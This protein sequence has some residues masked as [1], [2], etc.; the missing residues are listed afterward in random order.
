[1]DTQINGSSLSSM[2]SIHVTPESTWDGLAA[3]LRSGR[4][5]PRQ[6]VLLVLPPKP[7]PILVRP[8]DFRAFKRLKRELDINM[9]FVIPGQGNARLRAWARQAG[10]PAYSTQEELGQALDR[11]LLR[12]PALHRTGGLVARSHVAGSPGVDQPGALSSLDSSTRGD[13]VLQT[14]EPVPEHTQR[15]VIHDYVEG[16]CLEDYLMH[17]ASPME[18]IAVLAIGAQLLETLKNLAGQ[19]LPV[20]HGDIRPAN[21]VINARDNRVHLIG[22]PGLPAEDESTEGTQERR[23]GSPGYASPEQVQG[24]ADGRSD[25]YSL[26]ATMHRLLTNCDPA[27]YPPHNYPPVTLYNPRIS[28]ETERLLARAL[29]FDPTL[30]YQSAAE[31]KR[32]VEALLAA[33]RSVPQ[34]LLQSVALETQPSNGKHPPLGQAASPQRRWMGAPGPPFR[35]KRLGIAGAALLLLLVAVV[36]TASPLIFAPSP[37]GQPARAA[38]GLGIGV[39]RAPDGE[40]IGLSDGNFAFDTGADRSDRALKIQASARFRAGDIGSAET[41]WSSAV[42]QDTSDAE[43]LIYLEDQRVKDSG[44]PYITLVVGTMNSGTYVGLG[45]DDLQGA[46]IAQHEYNA[47]LKLPGKEQ[48]RLLI[49]STGNERDYAVPVAQQIVRAAQSDPTIVGV[50]GWPYSSRTENVVAILANARIPILSQMASSV[51]LTGIS[52]YFFRIVPPDSVQAALGA[53]YV[54]QVI[55]ARAAALFLDPSEAYSKSIGDSFKAKFTADGNTIVATEDY[56]IGKPETIPARL[57]DALSHNPDV[58]YFAGMAADA[59]TLLVNLPVSGPFA[60]LQIMGGDGL[61]EVH[62]YS[63]AA[64]PNF[65]RLRFT[66]FAYPDEW[67]GQ[68]LGR[69]APAFFRDYAS[70]FDPQ[71]QHTSAPYGYDRANGDAMLSYDA[72][73]VLLEAS[74]VALQTTPGEMLP[75]DLDR[76]LT[77]IQGPKA[78]QGVTGQIAFGPN[79]DPINKAVVVL[80][81]SP[82]RFIEM[83]GVQGTFLKS[84]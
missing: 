68:G 45:R 11:G 51:A 56:T 76:A 60:H 28:P 53:R 25:L 63:Q 55:H 26:A 38:P 18:E 48:V 10:F 43:A 19:S 82:E 61:Y 57:Q 30:R 41:L 49:A 14:A 67:E 1:M 5:M 50:M 71:R 69:Q 42:G 8:D 58:I 44:Y 21:I 66:A 40:Y 6:P 36:L 27:T 72:V 73:V 23:T 35:G 9:F 54:E 3:E 29:T 65:N 13:G 15:F 52:P 39:S 79:G 46:Y 12:S 70:T 80:A 84:G 7:V 16:E 2:H 75:S 83:K 78:I 22:F 24:E 4:T 34:V 77:M 37:H 32:D 81:V 33:P 17:H 62:S 74:R 47:G 59:N 20:V 64:R 31:M